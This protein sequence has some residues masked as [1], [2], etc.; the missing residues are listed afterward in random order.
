MDGL[1]FRLSDNL[2]PLQTLDICH[3]IV[4]MTFCSERPYSL[5]K[6][7][8]NRSVD[9]YD[10]ESSDSGVAN[11]VT[12]LG[13]PLTPDSRVSENS[14]IS[15]DECEQYLMAPPPLPS[16]VDETDI[17]SWPWSE[18]WAANCANLE[19]FADACG[20]SSFGKTNKNGEL[21]DNHKLNIFQKS[22]KLNA[23]FNA[24]PLTQSLVQSQCKLKESPGIKTH[25]ECTAPK[26]FPVSDEESPKTFTV[27]NKSDDNVSGDISTVQSDI[28]N[29]KS[30]LKVEDSLLTEK[31]ESCTPLVCSDSFNEAQFN[32]CNNIDTSITDNLKLK[33]NITNNES[34]YN[35]P[36]KKLCVDQKLPNKSRYFMR[37][38]SGNKK[39]QSKITQLL[40]KNINLKNLK[41]S[42][43]NPISKRQSETNGIIKN[44][45]ST[46]LNSVGSNSS[47]I[48]F[49][50]LDTHWI[51]LRENIICHWN[52]C[53]NHFNDITKFLE[54][55]QVKHVDSQTQSETFVCLWSG[56][57]VFNKP[58]CS[59]S[60]LQRHILTHA[61]N[62]PLECIV[63][64]CRQRFSSQLMLE[65]HVNHH[66]KSREDDINGKFIRRKGKKLRLRKQ[67]FTARKFDYFDQAT[68]LEL[69]T[70]LFLCT[71]NSQQDFID[72]SRRTIK[73]Q[74]NIIAKRVLNENNK[75]EVLMRWF[76]PNILEDEWISYDNKTNFNV[77]E[78]V[79]PIMSLSTE[80]RDSITKLFGNIF[81]P[82][83]RRSRK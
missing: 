50:K 83:S 76:P 57:K 74:P 54:H 23:L 10:E 68:M 81:P 29:D 42:L 80:N 58:S 36:H 56:C 53:D 15:P 71:Q 48:R 4:N 20:A 28:L 52:G 69:Q 13:S 33:S 6:Y 65:R 67:P 32:L 77:M 61:G 41:C 37:S 49:P 43:R 82:T 9:K 78:R 24:L 38:S 14:F 17:A 25:Y 46:K 27:C 39:S 35:N 2:D 55:L 31:L 34:N 7:S 30:L 63:Q 62:K 60:W 79:V 22:A 12:E 8:K 3:E 19:L 11:S 16:C 73:F 59:S 64:K 70:Q 21:D 5:K 26:K 40:D 1:R 51:S 72:F 18:Q 45:E 44:N 47:K 75:L 66:F